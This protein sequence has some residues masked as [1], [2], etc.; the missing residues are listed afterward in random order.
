MFF[1]PCVLKQRKTTKIQLF[2]VTSIYSDYSHFQ[3]KL[4]CFWYEWFSL[5]RSFHSRVKFPR[6]PKNPNLH[7]NSLNKLLLYYESSHKLTNHHVADL[8]MESNFHFCI[9]QH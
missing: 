3:Y 4:G 6:V 8:K 5:K 9:L 7:T 2:L 1:Y